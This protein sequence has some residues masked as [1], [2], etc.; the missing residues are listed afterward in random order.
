MVV[1]AQGVH[2][3]LH[4]QRTCTRCMFRC[5]HWLCPRWAAGHRSLRRG[6][7]VRG[8]IPGLSRKPAARR[9]RRRMRT[10]AGLPALSPPHSHA[11]LLRPACTPP[12]TQ[13]PGICGRALCLYWR[14]GPKQHQVARRCV[15]LWQQ[16]RARPA[17]AGAGAPAQPGA[18]GDR[19]PVCG[20]GGWDPRGVVP[21]WRLPQPDQVGGVGVGGGGGWIGVRTVKLPAAPPPPTH[22]HTHPTHPPLP[23]PTP[24]P[25]QAAPG[26]PQPER[27]PARHPARR[28]AGAAAAAPGAALAEHQPAS[29]LG[30]RH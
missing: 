28:A 25:A 26:G 3:V 8:G 19:A 17:A 13:R 24:S 2:I 1:L 29:K 20:A 15:P 9:W 4:V 5:V 7:L 18:P 27:P 14:H 10:P 30:G 12:G 16:G 6:C 23:H 22:T 21:G 11:R